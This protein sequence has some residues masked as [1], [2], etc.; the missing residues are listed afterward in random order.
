MLKSRGWFYAGM[1]IAVLCVVSPAQETVEGRLL[2]ILKEKG[3]IDGSEYKDLKEL[4]A[5][6]RREDDLAAQIDTRIEEM[7]TSVQETAPTTSY[8]VGKGFTWQTADKRF[9]LSVGGRLQVRFTADFFD[10][11]ANSTN[12]EDE[13]DFDVPR[14]RVWLQG[15]VFETYLKYKFQFDIAGDE[16][17]TKVSFPNG[18]SPTFSSTNRLTEMKDG[19]FDFTKWKYFS[20]RGGQFKVPYSRH[21]LTSSGKQEFV[22]RG[23]TDK[24]FAPGRN[25][26]LMVHGKAGGEASDLFEYY[27]GAF[28]GEG[29]NKTNNDEGLMFAG[30]LAVNPLGGVKYT[31]SDTG[32]SDDFVLAV[33]VNGWI[34]EDDNHTGAGDDWSI[35]ADIAAFYKGFFA[36]FEI[37]YR[38]NDVSGGSDVE[39]IGWIAQLGY[40]IVPHEF[41]IAIRASNIDWDNNGS[42]D[43]ARREYLIVLGYFWHAHNMK[44]QLDFGRI[45]DHEGDHDDNVDEWRL[46]IQFQI[47]F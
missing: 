13:L 22:D 43:S 2:K 9:K 28:D 21:Q 18:S 39:I 27:F 6:M 25:V 37:H 10:N 35:G 16:A 11:G 44:I 12:D 46:R 3:V 32:H 30:R 33:A 5:Q 19:Y 45:E 24:V 7:V 47:I 4:E 36:M 17:D 40:F 34:H 20:L 26:G 31:E 38:E 41:E 1:A 15:N 23:I 29:E 42:G 14:A 8:Q